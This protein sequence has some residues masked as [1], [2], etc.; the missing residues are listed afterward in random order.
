[1]NSST[2]IRPSLDKV[3]TYGF[4]GTLASKPMAGHELIDLKALGLVPALGGAEQG[5]S[6]WGD[7]LQYTADGRDISELWTVYQESLQVFNEH[8]QRIIDFLTYPVTNVIEDVP[9][10]GQADFE[11]ASEFG[12]PKGQRN[13]LNY[14]SLAYDFKWYDLAQRMTWKF[15]AEATAAQVDALHQ[16]ALEADNRLVFSRVMKTIF[17]NANSKTDIRNQPYTVYRFYNADGTVPTKYGSNTFTGTHTHYTTSGAAV[18][19]SGDV[20]AL[21]GQL[22]EHGYSPQNGNRIV[23][24]ANSQEAEAIRRFRANVANN[25]GAVALYDFVPATNQPAM[26]VP[27]TTGLIG[28]QVPGELNGLYVI[29]SYGNVIIVEDDYIPAGYM[30]M[31]ATGGDASLNNPVGFREH[32]NPALRGLRL[33]PGNTNGYPLV[34]SFYNRGFGTGIRQRGGG[35]VMQITASAS[36]AVPAQYV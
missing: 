6:T 12:E 15:L 35:A 10:G 33:L 31:F 25:N 19:D 5:T 23:L 32:A 4:P 27:N 34:D 24:M 11:E 36:Y 2:L 7:V 13:T 21:L 20:E 29:G 26:I 28:S 22:R 8:R 9:Q 3:M 30:F 1:M 14:F 17:N 18:V 16:Q